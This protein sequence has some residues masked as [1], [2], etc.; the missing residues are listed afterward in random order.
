LNSHSTPSN[1]APIKIFQMQSGSQ[2]VGAVEY[3]SDAVGS[4]QVL[5]RLLE[6]YVNPATESVAHARQCLSVFFPAYAAFSGWHHRLICLATVPAARLALLSG[7]TSATAKAAAPSL[8]RFVL[9][10]LQVGDCMFTV[11][12]VPPPSSKRLPPS[13]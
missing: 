4:S 11:G 6:A 3:A 7:G 13:R 8:L 1:K 5:A 12:S 2:L 10:Q 9:Q